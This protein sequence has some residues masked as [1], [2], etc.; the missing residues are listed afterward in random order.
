MQI[1]LPLQ[2]GTSA[3]WDVARA[4]VTSAP[5]LILLFGAGL[6]VAGRAGNGW[7]VAGGA[8]AV[9]LVVALSAARR[10]WRTR[11]SDVLFDAD[12]F[13]LEGGL[14]HGLRLAWSEIASDHTRVETVREARFT[15][16]GFVFGLLSA[17]LSSGEKLGLTE[18][19]PIRRLHLGTHDGRAFVLAEAEHLA[20]QASLDALIGTVQARLDP[21]P[22]GA[23]PE[24]A[25]EVLT[26]GSCGAPV[27]PAD[28]ATIAC[29]FCAHPN[30]VPQAVRQRLQEHR[31][32]EQSRQATARAVQQL[33]DQPGARYAS[34]VLLVAT[35][36]S[37]IPWLLAVVVLSLLGFTAAGGFEIGWL[38]ACGALAALATFLLA[39]IALANRRAL[40]LVALGFG[41]RTLP[42][43]Q[44]GY[45]C[46]RCGGP[47][48]V[49]SSGI[50]ARCAYCDAD[51][52]LG[53]DL[54]GK[55]AAAQHQ[56]THLEEALRQR[57][58]ER[59]RWLLVGLAAVGISL[60]AGVMATASVVMAQEH[61]EY[62]TACATG[63]G[64]A[65]KKLATDFQLGISVA[66]NEE[67]AFEFD[68]K[69][70]QLGHPEACYDLSER[71]RY[72]WGVSEDLE[73][74]TATRTKACQLGW[75]AAC[76]EPE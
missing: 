22:S 25:P 35:A 8:G 75:S 12:G 67:R 46:R 21:D 72:G 24:A 34:G 30:P 39:R 1:R 42:P 3:L 32:V 70:C 51:N 73:R 36:L 6:A 47:L 11:P 69:A 66:K 52:V 19:L 41:A 64:Q 45:A 59:W 38:L 76:Q 16:A 27:T 74:A 15:L 28:R 20:E 53:L 49:A 63:D 44:G 43:D 37:G 62:Q 17:W 13:R 56:R 18:E 61:A 40:H 65:C 10:A 50:V 48:P 26:C 57:S 14:H 2:V 29:R 58:R 4:S 71:Y 33:L 55:V 23:A 7:Y 54:G 5:A 60:V 31:R 9:L 68:T